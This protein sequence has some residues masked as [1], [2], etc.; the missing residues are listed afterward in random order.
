MLTR[1]E[2]KNTGLV[3]TKA[4]HIREGEYIRLLFLRNELSDTARTS[5]LRCKYITSDHL[6]YFFSS[7]P[8]DFQV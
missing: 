7:K 3:N 1:A 8:P 2:H 4:T 6:G 5:E